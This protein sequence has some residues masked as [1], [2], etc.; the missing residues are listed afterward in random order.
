MNKN[1]L[2][3]FFFVCFFAKDISNMR[4]CP[5]TVTIAK[6]TPNHQKA[7]HIGQRQRLSNNLPIYFSF[8]LTLQWIFWF[9]NYFFQSSKVP[10]VKQKKPQDFFINFFTFFIDDE[11]FYHLCSQSVYLTVCRGVN[12]DF[13]FALGCGF[14][15][16]WASEFNCLF[17]H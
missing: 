12:L 13:L 10:P 1:P 14:G 16:C 6:L 5:Y 2:A 3:W 8:F 4:P 15:R 11:P 17:A 9:L 7:W